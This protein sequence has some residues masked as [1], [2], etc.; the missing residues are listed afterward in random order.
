MLNTANVDT[1]GHKEWGIGNEEWGMGN[2]N[3]DAM[4]CKRF[5]AQG[6]PRSSELEVEV[7][8][9]VIK[10]RGKDRLEVSVLVVKGA[11]EVEVIKVRGKDRR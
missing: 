4:N 11:V 8:V 1:L 3:P 6:L 9:E 5:C 10:V 7:K 2:R